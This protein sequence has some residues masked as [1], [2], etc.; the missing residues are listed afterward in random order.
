MTTEK[1]DMG[2]ET[3]IIVWEVCTRC[4]LLCCVHRN[5]YSEAFTFRKLQAF[6]SS[7]L[8]SLPAASH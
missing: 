6:H 1:V 3:V 8:H 5:K 7:Q 4:I 2:A